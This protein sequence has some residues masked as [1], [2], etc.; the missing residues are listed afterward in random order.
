MTHRNLKFKAVLGAALLAFGSLASAALVTSRAALGGD[1]FFD[2]AQLTPTDQ[3]TLVPLATPASV[4]SSLG[5]GATVQN[6]GGGLY[7]FAENDGTYRSHFTDGDAVLYTLFDSGN[8]EIDFDAATGRAGAQ[9]QGVG[10]PFRATIAAYALGGALLE[11]WDLDGAGFDAL[12]A[13]DG[14]AIFIGI[15]RATNDIDRLVF[16]VSYPNDPQQTDFSLAIN[17]LSFG[18]TATNPGGGGSVPEPATLAL[19][20]LGLGMTGVM[21]RP[22]RR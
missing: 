3:S 21:R 22:G 2:W 20:M 18:P 17:S 10:Q 11:T 14:S 7:R 4:T 9:I 13:G 15:S 16:S 12:T 5:R 6:T 19:L 1:D 8:I